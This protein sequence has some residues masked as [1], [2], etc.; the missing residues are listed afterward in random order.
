MS[1]ILQT[2]ESA[3]VRFLA[4]QASSTHDV[5]NS[6]VLATHAIAVDV[7]PTGLLVTQ[8]DATQFRLNLYAG[9][10]ES[11]IELPAIVVVAQAG[12]S[13]EDVPVIQVVPVEITLEASG[14]S[15]TGFDSVAWIDQAARWLHDTLNKQEPIER[16]LEIADPRIAVSG[17]VVNDHARAT[18]GRRR[19]RR[20]TLEV[21]ASI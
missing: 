9:E 15:R 13:M 3:F 12:R 1:A 19:I 10:S 16:D 6:F 2:L 17:V 5:V 4:T 14:D 18:D 11:E 21:T 7:I 20:W 8:D